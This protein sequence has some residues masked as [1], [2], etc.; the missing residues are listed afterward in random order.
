MKLNFFRI[1]PA[2]ALAALALVAACQDVVQPKQANP[3]DPFAGL[4]AGLHPV[5]VVTEAGPVTTYA[6]VRLRRVQ[7]S[8]SIASFQAQLAYDTTQLSVLGADFPA[9]VDGAWHEVSP[10]QV[11]FAGAAAGGLDDVAL[12]TLRFASK[13]PAGQ[14]T[15]SLDF[16]ELVGANDFSDLAPMVAAGSP[17]I[18]SAYPAR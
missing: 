9:G 14:R 5:L 16:Q 13:K 10:G 2:F 8:A 15:F 18:V 4:K 3:G 17:L 6:E 12:A 7:T 1:R 11:R